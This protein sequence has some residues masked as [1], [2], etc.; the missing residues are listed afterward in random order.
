MPAHTG[1]MSIPEPAALP[2]P[3]EQWPSQPEHP[4]DTKSAWHRLNERH[5]LLKPT[6][7]L[8]YCAFG[9]IGGW[10]LLC[11]LAVSNLPA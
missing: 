6:L 2:T 7:D 8:L 9:I 1:Y 10:A 11:A 5:P 4:A 3:T